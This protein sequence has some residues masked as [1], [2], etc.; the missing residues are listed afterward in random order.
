[1]VASMS[2]VGCGGNSGNEGGNGGEEPAGPALVKCFK[3]DCHDTFYEGRGKVASHAGKD[4]E[5]CTP[6][7]QEMFEG[8]PEWYLR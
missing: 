5:F 1:M 3:F 7:C 4:Y 8:D 2:A 6:A